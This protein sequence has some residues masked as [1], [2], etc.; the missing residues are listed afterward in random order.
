MRA[1]APAPAPQRFAV[2]SDS[3]GKLPAGIAEMAAAGL[4]DVVNLGDLVGDLV[5]GPLWP[6]ETGSPHARW[7]LVERA[8]GGHWRLPLRATP[9]DFEAAARQA[10]GNGRGDGAAA[11]RT[12]RV[13]RWQRDREQ[14]RMKR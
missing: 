9:Y 6:T 12:G 7:A 14:K 5:S 13:G 10:E 3:H 1:A 11:L 4:E 2:V 8:D